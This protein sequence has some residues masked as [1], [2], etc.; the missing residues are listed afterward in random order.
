MKCYIHT[1]QDAVGACVACGNLICGTCEVDV[2]GRKHC[3]KCVT[4]VFQERN[5]QSQLPAQPPPQQV[6][7]N[8]GGGGGGGQ[9]NV[10]VH[11][12]FNHSFHLVITLLTCGLWLPVWI[13]LAL[14]D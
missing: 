9:T 5:S 8:A 1:D 14:M 4:R 7:M 2:D 3:K 6:F 11:K 13:I 12:P 10:V